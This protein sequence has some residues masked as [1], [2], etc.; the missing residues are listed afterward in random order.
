[1]TQTEH[2]S[3]SVVRCQLM[4]LRRILENL[5]AYNMSLILPKIALN[6]RFFDL[7]EKKGF[8]ITPVHFY[9]PIPDTRTLKDELWESESELV[10]IDMK[11]KEQLKLLTHVF[12]SFRDEYKFPRKK[13]GIP[14]EYYLEN[15]FFPS[16]DAGV[17]HAMIR[18]F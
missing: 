10:G 16:V 15:G 2:A 3:K 4:S 1:M 9:E 11:P 13:T 18:Y 6:K 14:Y 12:S 5:I 17:L 7:W 8:H